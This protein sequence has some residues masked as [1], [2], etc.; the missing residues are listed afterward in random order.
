MSNYLKTCSATF[1]QSTESLIPEAH[2]HPELL[3]GSV[4]SQRLQC[5]VTSFLWKYLASDNF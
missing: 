4:E 1:P 5:L 3:L 2:F